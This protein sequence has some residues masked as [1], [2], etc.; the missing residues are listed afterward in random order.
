MA[1]TLIALC[2][3]AVLA[4]CGSSTEGA[5][6]SAENLKL[7]H[8]DGV[9]DSSAAA[10]FHRHSPD[11]NQVAFFKSTAESSKT[12]FSDRE[13][14]LTVANANGTQERALSEAVLTTLHSSPPAWSPNGEWLA[15]RLALP[16][17]WGS[18]ACL[19][20]VQPNVTDAS[21]KVIK[22]VLRPSSRPAW[23]P[24]SARLAVVAYGMS[25]GLELHVTNPEGTVHLQVSVPIE[26]HLNSSCAWTPDGRS[27][28]LI[29]DN[30]LHL[31]AVSS[32]AIQVRKVADTPYDSSTFTD[33]PQWSPSGDKLAFITGSNTCLFDLKEESVTQILAG[34]HIKALAWVEGEDSLLVVEMLKGA[35]DALTGLGEAIRTIPRIGF[36]SHHKRTFAPLLFEVGSGAVHDLSPKG[37]FFSDGHLDIYQ[38]GNRVRNAFSRLSQ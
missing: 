25:S 12:R 19:A 28:V 15:C 3:L 36:D 16:D 33:A 30:A 8:A 21:I 29:A 27:I 38:M 37:Y 10:V 18:S 32:E 14:A 26:T 13:Y 5:P 34:R 23:S 24:D 35:P 1:Q 31:C 9:F 7:A 11:R 4:S 2:A 20:L 22:R 17:E 6:L